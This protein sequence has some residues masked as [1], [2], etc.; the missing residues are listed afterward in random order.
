MNQ[1][2]RGSSYLIFHIF[3]NPRIF[4]LTRM[5]PCRIP[6]PCPKMIRT[7]FTIRIASI[8]TA[9]HSKFPAKQ[10][11][12]LFVPL[13]TVASVEFIHIHVSCVPAGTTSFLL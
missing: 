12:R 10:K 1:W 9:T 5:F 3:A 7:K 4:D 2:L 11:I 8:T 6:H 13:G